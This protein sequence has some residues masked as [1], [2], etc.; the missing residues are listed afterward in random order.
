MNKKIAL[1]TIFLF[2]MI[3]ILVY[4]VYRVNQPSNTSKSAIE[5]RSSSAL[6]VEEKE[7][8]SLLEWYETFPDEKRKSDI[9]Q[10]IVQGKGERRKYAHTDSVRIAM[11]VPGVQRSDYWTRNQKAFELR[12]QELGLPYRLETFFSKPDE[13]ALRYKQIQNVMK[14]K[15]DYLITTL[16]GSSDMKMMERIIAAGETKVILQNITTPLTRFTNR[17]PFLY[18]GFDH[19]LGATLLA[20]EYIRK[21]PDGG[22]W[23]LLLFTDGLVSEQRGGAFRKVI[24][25]DP[26]MNLKAVYLTE[27]KREK[28][29]ESVLS[30]FEDSS[31]VNFIYSCATDVTVGALEALD[32]IGL[33]DSVFLNGWGGGSLELELIE[34][35][36]L[37]IT[38]MRMNDD[39]AIA[40]AEAISLDILGNSHEI[41]LVYSGMFRVVS[42]DDRATI[43][44]L[45]ARAFRYSNREM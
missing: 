1:L 44:M 8:W 6:I 25:A 24:D 4:L 45:K 37:D 21:F 32:S 18:T 38:V 28:A 15:Y 17:Q 27:G 30:A 33:G 31:S 26:N 12:C 11:V 41:P 14:A 35:G 23:I 5:G 2:L 10:E 3:L 36:N 20:H 43:P 40:I 42:I 13:V 29:R 16:D 34:K 7:Q 22:D 19:E 9:F 39:A